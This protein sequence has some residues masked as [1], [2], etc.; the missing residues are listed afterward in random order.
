MCNLLGI[1]LWRILWAI[2]PDITNPDVSTPW[3]WVFTFPKG[4]GYYEFYTIGKDAGSSC[5]KEEL[6]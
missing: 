4:V 6:N 1:N 5:L 3:S 2:W